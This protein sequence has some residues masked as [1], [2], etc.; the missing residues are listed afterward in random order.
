MLGRVSCTQPRCA[1]NLWSHTA[2]RLQVLPSCFLLWGW[3][4]CAK[5]EQE[6]TKV[7]QHW[8]PYAAGYIVHGITQDF[9]KNLGNSQTRYLDWICCLIHIFPKCGKIIVRCKC[10][11]KGVGEWVAATLLYIPQSCTSCV[12]VYS[13]TS[14][15]CVRIPQDS[16]KFHIK[17]S[18]RNYSLIFWGLL[19]VEQ[20]LT[21]D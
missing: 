17:I 3:A 21:N 2:T 12:F 16:C 7:F 10:Y 9:T 5:Q 6:S 14:A 15:R 4:L 18:D 13:V 1:T 8:L 19:L 11:V 20:Y